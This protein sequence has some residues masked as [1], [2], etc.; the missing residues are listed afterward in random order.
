MDAEF[1]LERSMTRKYRGPETLENPLGHFT[2]LPSA[3]PAYRNGVA[4]DQSYSAA[5][6]RYS[7]YGHHSQ[8][9]VPVK[10]RRYRRSRLSQPRSM[11]QRAID[12]SLFLEVT[13]VLMVSFT[14][15]WHVITSTDP[16][17]DSDDEAGG[18]EYAREDYSKLTYP[19][20]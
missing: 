19:T 16:L 5:R 1:I 11:L 8:P 14:E 13:L 20:I 2:A 17:V 9:A 10:E 12:L 15:A 4:S 7:P 3:Q 6:H 18:D